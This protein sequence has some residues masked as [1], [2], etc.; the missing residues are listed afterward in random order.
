MKAFLL[1]ALLLF[2][3]ACGAYQFPGS[4]APQTG[5]VSGRILVYPCAPVE[6]ASGGACPGRPAAGVEIDFV[7]AKTVNSAVTD[8][9]GDYVIRL[10]PDTYQVQFKQY[11]HFVRGPKT[12]T[13]TADTNV[14]ANYIIDSGL[15]G[16][17]P[18]Q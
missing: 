7:N 8:Q 16:P 3:A 5:T 6:P 2:T 11:P 1:G 4:P 9:K 18:V 17:G 12:V 13:V 14:V 15:R 10:S